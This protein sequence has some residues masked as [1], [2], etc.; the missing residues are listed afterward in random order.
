MSLHPRESQQPL[1]SAVSAW[2]A[3]VQ[4]RIAPRAVLRRREGT[5]FSSPS[6]DEVGAIH[7]AIRAERAWRARQSNPGGAAQRVSRPQ[8]GSAA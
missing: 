4:A 3:A 8:V 6:D 7:G 2:M 1:M 5:R